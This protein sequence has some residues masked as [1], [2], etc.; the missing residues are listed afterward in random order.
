MHTDARSGG[1]KSCLK[2]VILLP[3]LLMHW[4]IGFA[5][6]GGYVLDGTVVETGQGVVISVDKKNKQ[7]TIAHEAVPYILKKGKTHFAVA[8]PKVLEEAMANMGSRVVFE[9]RVSKGDT[10]IAHIEPKKSSDNQ[11]QR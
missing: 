1:K 9:I 2:I 10:V 7:V 11:N 5:C 6:G 8:G 4:E 3:L